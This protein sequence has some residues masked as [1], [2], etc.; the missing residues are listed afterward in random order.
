MTQNADISDEP[1]TPVAGGV[2]SDFVEKI[3]LIA[4][5]EGVPRIAGRLFGLLVFDG[6]ALS[7]SELA[8]MLQVSRASISSSV[9]LLEDRE[10]IKR[11]ARP[12]DRQD[13]FQLADNPYA[14]LLELTRTRAT[15]A[16]HDIEMSLAELAP[17][18]SNDTRARIAAYANFYRS[19]E[20]GLSEA[21]L[22]LSRR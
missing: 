4:Q 21:L 22:T 14:G 9:R 15:R 8:T 2:R 11:V 12:G 16:R 5:G 1:A 6:N 10:L 3:G 13:Y 20:D 19:I 17:D 18:D 7:F